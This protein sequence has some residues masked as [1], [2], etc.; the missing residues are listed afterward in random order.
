M[1]AKETVKFLDLELL[2]SIALN[3]RRKGLNK[4]QKFNAGKLALKLN[5]ALTKLDCPILH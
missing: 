4:G 5:Q 1:Q 3:D 2:L